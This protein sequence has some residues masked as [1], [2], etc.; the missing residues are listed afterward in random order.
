MGGR[1]ILRLLHEKPFQ[2]NVFSI[3]LHFN[4]CVLLLL[5]LFLICFCALASQSRADFWLSPEDSPLAGL[6]G[7]GISQEC[8]VQGNTTLHLKAFLGLAILGG[9]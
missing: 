3:W 7:T 9:A 4:Y 1:S 5:L 2:F 6:D 8:P